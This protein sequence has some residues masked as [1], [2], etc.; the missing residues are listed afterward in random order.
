MF[1]ALPGRLNGLVQAILNDHLTWLI[2]RLLPPADQIPNL[3]LR[4]LGSKEQKL[5]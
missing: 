2:A 3:S 5:P 1:I 4:G